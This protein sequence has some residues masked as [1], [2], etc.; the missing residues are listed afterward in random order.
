MLERRRRRDGGR[1]RPGRARVP[2]LLE[3]LV[4]EWDAL[5]PRPARP[6]PAAARGRSRGSHAR[7]DRG[8]LSARP[9]SRSPTRERSREA[10]LRDRAR[11][12][13][14]RRPRGPLDAPARAP[15]ER[16][17]RRSRSMALGHV[18]RLGL[19][20]RR[21][22]AARRRAR[23]ASCASSAAR[24]VTGEPRRRA[25]PPPTSCSPTSRRAS[26]VRIARRRLPDRYERALQPLPVRRRARSRSTGR[27]T[28]PIPWRAE[29]CRARRDGPP[30]RHARRDRARRSGRRG[31]AGTPSGRSSSSPST[32]LFDPTRA[33]DGQAHRLGVLP[34]AE[35]LDDVD[36][37]ERIEAQVERF[38]PGFRDLVLARSVARRRPTS[39]RGTG[40][41]SAATST[42][43]RWTSA[44]SSRARRAKLVPVPHAARGRLPLLGRD[45]A[46][47]RRPRHV[48][49]LGRAG[50]PRRSRG[51]ACP[52]P[53][54]EGRIWKW[55]RPSGRSRAHARHSIATRGKTPSGC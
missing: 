15:A 26:C 27:S 1:A 17:V 31:A 9:A 14:L 10:M 32:T 29:Q 54:A 13:A 24:S 51:T 19:P 44:S 45:A 49:L 36:M 2:R 5:E 38:A 18:V 41:S 47:R 22:A 50:C 28:A 16:R 30:R 8:E 34:R 42:A 46:R 11:P 23:R 25:A 43:A 52:A 40:T 53:V 3:P 21:L 4:E 55:R 39:R 33:P 12:R 6:A 7:S 48:R 35:R 20:A 37:T